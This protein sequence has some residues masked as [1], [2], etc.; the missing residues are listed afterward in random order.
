MNALMILDVHTA[1]AWFVVVSNGL[2]GIWSLTA[3]RWPAL[4]SRA[5]WWFTA[6]SQATMLVQVILG[7]IMLNKYKL[8][9]PKFHMFYG[10]VGLIA[11]TILYS[12]RVQLKHKLYLLYGFGGIFVMGLGIRAMLVAAMKS[13]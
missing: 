6:A 13:P 9:A 8:Q 10:F 3:H 2:A 5:L 7:V 11:I 12:Y 1:W 4:R